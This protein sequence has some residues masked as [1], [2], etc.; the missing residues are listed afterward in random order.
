MEMDLYSI[1]DDMRNDR[2][3][4]PPIPGAYPFIP[5]I[6]D[7]KNATLIRLLTSEF[8]QPKDEE[9]SFVDLGCGIGNIVLLVAKAR[10]KWK[11]YGFDLDK[12]CIE[13]A[14]ELAKEYNISNAEFE[15]ANIMNMKHLKHYARI[16]TYQPLDN[17]KKYEY[18]CGHIINNMLSGSMWYEYRQCKII[19]SQLF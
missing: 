18:L 14:K 1:A 8:G 2:R 5:S 7:E 12:I 16:Y 17:I 13:K 11:C 10:P 6:T 3:N 15:V 9:L 19:K 4:S